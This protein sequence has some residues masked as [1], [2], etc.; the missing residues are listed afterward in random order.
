ML[1]IEKLVDASGVGGVLD[2]FAVDFGKAGF[3]FGD[4][5]FEGFELAFFVEGE[6]FRLWFWAF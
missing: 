5:F 3:G 1:F 6:F 4:A 2:H